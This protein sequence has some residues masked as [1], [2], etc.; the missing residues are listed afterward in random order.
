MEIR[1]K[2]NRSMTHA[3]DIINA[4]NEKCVVED[5]RM[6]GAAIRTVA[7]IE[8]NIYASPQ[9][10]IAARSILDRLRNSSNTALSQEAYVNIS[11]A[12]ISRAQRILRPDSNNLPKGAQKRSTEQF[13]IKG[14][15]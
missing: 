14:S 11:R 9:Q 13:I 15:T 8:N 10:K 12:R 2:I 6:F 1:K 7:G 4:F 5:E 3:N